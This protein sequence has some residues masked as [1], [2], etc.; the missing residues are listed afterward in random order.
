MVASLAASSKIYCQG[1]FAF[2][3]NGVFSMCVNTVYCGDECFAYLCGLVV[4]KSSDELLSGA[5]IRRV[6]G[7]SVGKRG[8]V[9]GEGAGGRGRYS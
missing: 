6:G 2:A 4:G 1:V 8:R 7:V 9:R 5:A 3:V